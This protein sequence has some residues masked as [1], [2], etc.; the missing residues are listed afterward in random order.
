[1]ATAYGFELPGNMATERTNP[2]AKGLAKMG[3]TA[4]RT[5]STGTSNTGKKTEATEIYF[6]SGNW[7]TGKGCYHTDPKCW[8]LTK[9]T[10]GVASGLQTAAK[11]Q[12]LVLCR[13]CPVKT[14][15]D[16]PLL[17]ELTASFDRDG[18]DCIT[19][20]YMFSVTANCDMHTAIL[21]SC[22]TAQ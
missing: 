14:A 17:D 22:D 16:K 15:E 8:A 21:A 20:I 18:S 11:E 1:M 3:E 9:A 6:T 4:T 2:C 13:M 7:Q 5:A 12:G 19:D 10:T